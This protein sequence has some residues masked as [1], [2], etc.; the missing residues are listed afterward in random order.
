MRYYSQA[1]LLGLHGRVVATGSGF[2]S[3]QDLSIF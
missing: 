3:L 2:E 1:I